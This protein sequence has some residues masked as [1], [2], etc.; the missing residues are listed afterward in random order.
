MG[1]NAQAT[2]TTSP[3]ANTSQY[4]DLWRHAVA[5]LAGQVLGN[6][7]LQ[8]Y[9]G[10]SSNLGLPNYGAVMDATRANFDRQR[11]LVGQQVD[12]YAT[13][14]GAFG[15]NR[16]A[17][18]KAQGLND[19]NQNES[20]TLA[21]LGLQQQQDQ[22]QRILGILGMAGQG[23]YLGGQVNTQQMPSNTLGNIL[24]YGATLASLIP[25]GGASAAAAPV[26]W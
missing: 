2:S 16:S 11:G 4:Q 7:Q 13:R 15:G 23:N 26:M 6:Q 19:I 3:D 24:G 21:N 17:I 25:S 9:G 14:E 1:K 12:S 22:W 5:G 18:M 8:A 10:T 20:G